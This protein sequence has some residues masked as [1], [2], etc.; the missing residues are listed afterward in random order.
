[1]FASSREAVPVKILCKP[2]LEVETPEVTFFMPEEGG[3][4]PLTDPSLIVSEAGDAEIWGLLSVTGVGE[5]IHGPRR[6]VWD[7]QG[8]LCPRKFLT[9]VV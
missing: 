1:M 3:R 7:I 5:A 2:V 9:G 6:G 4:D 8:V